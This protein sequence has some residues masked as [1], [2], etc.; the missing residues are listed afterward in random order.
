MTKLNNIHP[1]EILYEEFLKPN[2]ITAI[3]W[4]RLFTSPKPV[5]LN[6]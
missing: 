1:G 2:N 4:Q 6:L 3:N 5:F